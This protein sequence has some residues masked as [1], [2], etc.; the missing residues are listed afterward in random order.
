MRQH[1]KPG[2]NGNALFLILIAVALFAALAYAVTQSGRGGG[3]GANAER[4]QLDL[5]R[6]MQDVSMV[7]SAVDRLTLTGCTKAQISFASAPSSTGTY[8]NAGAPADN[9]CHIFES[10]GGGVPA[11]PAPPASILNTAQS[12]LADYGRYLY[13]QQINMSGPS[14]GG[15]NSAYFIVPYLSDAACTQINQKLRGVSAIPTDNNDT[16]DL[17]YRYTGTFSSGDYVDCETNSPGPVEQ[18]GAEM[19]CLQVSSLLPAGVAANVFYSV[20]MKQ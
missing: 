4:L 9:S 16:I 12:A 17:F 13:I 3:G 10:N 8:A 5:A 19:G 14:A 11:Y 6:M 15:S 7:Q 20:L 18:C 2:R 1:S